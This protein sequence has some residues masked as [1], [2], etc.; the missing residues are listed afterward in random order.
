METSRVS[1][2][3]EQAR[4]T[5]DRLSRWYDLLSEASEARPRDAG[6]KRLAV[7]ESETVLDVGFGTGHSFIALAR[8]AGKTGRVYGIDLSSGMINVAR[9]LVERARMTGGVRL[10]CGDALSLPF[11]ASSFDAVF[12]SFTLELF[13][14]PDM[15]RVLAE[16]RR[17]LRAG[18]RIC[19]VAL[20][21]KEP[22]TW[23]TRLYEWAHGQ[24]PS[25]VDCR[26]IF[27]GRAM[28]DAGLAILDAAEMSMW[29]L[30]VGI[31]L[32]REPLK[33]SG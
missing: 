21:K 19:V 29:G 20:C 16:C 31:I 24:F 9:G 8:A 5:Y 6:L 25:Y 7:Q 14:T 3:K 30:P 15:P 18:G 10:A 11:P 27:V 13:D 32:G 28:E 22:W 12:M 4:T 17:V 26:P 23:V 2:T 1:R 33:R